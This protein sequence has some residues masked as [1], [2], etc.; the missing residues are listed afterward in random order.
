M[1]RFYGVCK[2]AYVTHAKKAAR[3]RMGA[4]DTWPPARLHGSFARRHGR[5]ISSALRACL[6]LFEC[7]RTL[8]WPCMCG[9]ASQ[10]NWPCWKPFPLISQ[11]GGGIL[12]SSPAFTFMN[13]AATLASP[14]RQ[15]CKLNQR[16]IVKW[17]FSTHFFHWRL[18]ALAVDLPQ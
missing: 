13:P 12:R 4:H 18:L 8:T 7:P 17:R 16:G 1:P 6:L 5:Q 2:Y 9:T 10:R 3:S 15:L 11:T 14:A